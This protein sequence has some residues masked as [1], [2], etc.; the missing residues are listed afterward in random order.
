MPRDRVLFRSCLTPQ[1]LL[2][3]SLRLLS[4]VLLLFLPLVGMSLVTV[5]L[6]ADEPGAAYIFP[7]GGQQGTSVKVRV[8]GLC[9]HEKCAW[10]MLGPG[11]TASSEI[12]RTETVWFEGPM[13]TAAAASQAEIYPQDYAGTVTIAA[14]APP[15]SRF[16]RLW[17]SQGA[18]PALRFIVDDLPEVIEQEQD[19]AA[20]PVE[21]TLP[22]TINGRIFPREDVDLWN[23]SAAAGQVV[24]IEASAA[25][26]GSPLQPQ[27]DLLDQHGRLVPAVAQVTDGDPV[28]LFTAPASG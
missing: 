22:V 14:D 25:R 10:Q 13:L 21:V 7:A 28:L 6:R 20:L 12:Q 2:R 15:G 3:A 16:W 24:R 23:F 4:R 17:T 8:G 9:L 26:I 19:G 5:P 27:L 1:S 11:V 18:T